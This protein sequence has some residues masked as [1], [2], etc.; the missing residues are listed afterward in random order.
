MTRGIQLIEREIESLRKTYQHVIKY[1]NYTRGSEKGL[2]EGEKAIDRIK[3]YMIE[4]EKDKS[5]LIN[6]HKG[7]L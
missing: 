3:K 7:T 5:I 6:I 1:H 4:L 2:N